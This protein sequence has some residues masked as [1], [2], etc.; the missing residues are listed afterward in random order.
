MP[1]EKYVR[2]D[3]ENVEQNIAKSNQHLPTR[4]KTPFMSGYCS[5]TDASPELKSEG[6]TQY[7]EMVGVLSW[8]VDLI[9]V[10]ILLETALMSTDLALPFWGNIKQ[11]LNMFMY[12]KLN[13]KRKL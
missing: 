2:A 6:V 8:S 4:C 5:E 1:E 9:Q 11:V 7:Q 13:P 3:V 10:D 12:L